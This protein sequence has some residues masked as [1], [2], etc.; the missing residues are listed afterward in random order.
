[1][2][3]D[4]ISLRMLLVC[5]VP[6]EQ[7]LWRQGAALASVPIEFD[8]ADAARAGK[9]L[10]RG[11]VDICIIDSKL[12]NDDKEA[13]LN[14]AR[15]VEPAPFVV[16]SAPSAVARLEG[17]DGTL[18][19]PTNAEDARKAVEMCVRVKIPTRVLIV[20]DSGTMR[21]IV[22]KILSASRFALDIHEA[23]EGTAALAQLRGGN[24]GMVFLDYNMPGLNGF[25]TLAEIKRENPKVAVVM[26]TAKMDEAMAKRAQASG[27]LSFLKKPFFPADIDSIL[28]R[29]YGLST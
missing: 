29:F 12:A 13:V 27:A 28:T 16:L 23:E 21:S 18:T 9:T 25:E 22:R 15:A 26:M 2:T 11:G 14:A 19:K 6:S 7:D 20:D 5:A 3:G 4:L 1:M 17:S 8:T 10:A 24:F